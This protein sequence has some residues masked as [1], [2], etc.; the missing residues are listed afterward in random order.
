MQDV[1]ALHDLLLNVR[2]SLRINSTSFQHHNQ[3]LLDLRFEVKKLGCEVAG[4]DPE[5]P[6]VTAVHGGVTRIEQTVRKIEHD[7]T[8]LK[9][10]V[11]AF[12]DQL[13]LALSRLP[14][15]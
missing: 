10:D 11:E 1:Q 13:D 2:R 6:D 9:A 15:R 3:L 14:E 7:V 8:G 5:A 12:K 4:L